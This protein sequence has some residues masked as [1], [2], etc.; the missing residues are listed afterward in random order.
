VTGLIA[1]W[2]FDPKTAPTADQLAEGL[3]QVIEAATRI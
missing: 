3:R 2:I 1:Q